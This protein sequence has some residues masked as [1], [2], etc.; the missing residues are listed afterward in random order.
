MRTAKKK[1]TT[2]IIMT[3]TT[4]VVAIQMKMTTSPVAVVGLVTIKKLNKKKSL[5]C[6]V[7]GSYFFT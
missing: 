5:S 3:T 7:I 4:L 1:V 6:E 2:M